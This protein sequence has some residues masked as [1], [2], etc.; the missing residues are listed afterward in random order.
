MCALKLIFHSVSTSPWVDAVVSSKV[1][2]NFET[3]VEILVK[4]Y[5]IFCGKKTFLKRRFTPLHLSSRLLL[6]QPLSSYLMASYAVAGIS[7]QIFTVFGSTATST[8]SLFF[9]RN[10]SSQGTSGRCTV[11]KKPSYRIRYSIRYNARIRPY[12]NMF[13]KTTSKGRR[14]LQARI[15]DGW[16][17]RSLQRL[18]ASGKQVLPCVICAVRWR[19]DS[20]G[21]CPVLLYAVQ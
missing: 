4:L 8:I 5:C 12:I 20:K 17:R 6:A 15:C 14:G 1:R 3:V 21:G 10:V 7:R 11:R 13:I 19:H 18:L 9:L 16:V 2:N